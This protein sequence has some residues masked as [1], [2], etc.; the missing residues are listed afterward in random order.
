M[1]GLDLGYNAV[2]VV[3][4]KNRVVFASAV[5]TPDTARFT[6]SEKGAT[7]LTYNGESFFFGEGAVSDSRLVTRRE[8]RHWIESDTYEKL[9]VAA[10]YHA[11]W[12]EAQMKGSNEFGKVYPAIVTGLP[13]AYYSDK[14]KL[15]KILSRPF[16]FTDGETNYSI[17]I[18]EVRVVPQPFGTILD[19]LFDESG[20]FY[21][22]ETSSKM[23]GV[24]DIG[25]KTT[26]ILVAQKLSEKNRLT[27]SVNL[28]GWDVVRHVQAEILKKYEVELRD[29]EVSRV[30][31]MRDLY[32]YGKQI[33]VESTINSAIRPVLA[34]ISSELT[35]IWGNAATI[36]KI[37]ITGGGSNFLG[38]YLMKLYPNQSEVV[39]DPVLANAIGYYKFSTRLNRK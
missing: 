29:H 6:L 17:V 31:A 39:L 14:D 15:A 32:I 5:G 20:E 23:I 7:I 12:Q 21:D 11:T 9:I 22:N 27:T 28:G 24:I 38:S 8:D 1:L 13:I 2:K 4:E 19:Y 3:S 18:K 26:N 25:G 35:R 37:L 33:D 16:V 36:D 10:L 30:I 34:G